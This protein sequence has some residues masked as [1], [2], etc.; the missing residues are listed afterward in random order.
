MARKTVIDWMLQA[1][2]HIRLESVNSTADPTNSQ[3][4]DSAWLR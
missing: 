1:M 2:P 3:R 4:V